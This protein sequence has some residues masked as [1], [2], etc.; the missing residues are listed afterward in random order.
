M[1]P[2][3][4][5]SAMR[6]EEAAVTITTM[7]ARRSFPLGRARSK[8]RL[9]AAELG[10]L[11]AA[12]LVVLLIALLPG[13]RDSVPA[14][15]GAVTI[16]VSTSETLWGIAK[17]HPIEGLTTAQT[18]AA[19]RSANELSDSALREGQLLRVPAESEN[20]AAMVSR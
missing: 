5:E 1:G 11:A 7:T 6:G 20:A 2:G 14:W 17:A 4:G 9:S 12:L 10:I 3:K 16:K 19:I 8:A 18:V 13:L 15:P